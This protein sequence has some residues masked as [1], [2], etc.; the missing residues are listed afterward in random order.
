ML[1]HASRL[2]EGKKWQGWHFNASCLAV[3]MKLIYLVLTTQN[4]Y[5]HPSLSCICPTRTPYYGCI[6]CKQRDNSPNLCPFCCCTS[7][8]CIPMMCCIPQ[9]DGTCQTIVSI[10]PY[11][12]PSQGIWPSSTYPV[13][14]EANSGA[15]ARDAFSSVLSTP[16]CKR[17]LLYFSEVTTP[18]KFL[19]EQTFLPIKCPSTL[20][21]SHR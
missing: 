7:K 18:P 9:S 6:C 8:W 19:S 13:F 10:S 16:P 3:N 4:C 2:G 1:V 14:H 21:M 17:L 12:F 15:H 5:P 20:S 11:F